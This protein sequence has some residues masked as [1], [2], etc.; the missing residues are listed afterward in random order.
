[1]HLVGVFYRKA[2]LFYFSPFPGDTVKID[3]RPVLYGQAKY[4]IKKEKANEVGSIIFTKL[5]EEVYGDMYD[6]R[7]VMRLAGKPD[8]TML[9]KVFGAERMLL[10]KMSMY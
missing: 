6:E 4:F 9:N 5:P 8:V 2:G 10:P 7:P 1:M 3:T